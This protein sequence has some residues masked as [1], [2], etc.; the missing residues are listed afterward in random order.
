MYS[1]KLL[2]RLGFHF[3]G[4]HYCDGMD[5]IHTSYTQKERAQ[6]VR[7]RLHDIAFFTDR[8]RTVGL[9]DQ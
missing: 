3:K 9:R 1:N 8:D 4:K 2:F 5:E 6:P 7:G